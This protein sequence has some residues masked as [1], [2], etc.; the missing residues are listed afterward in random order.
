MLTAGGESERA[1]EKA[2]RQLPNQVIRVNMT[3]TGDRVSIRYPLGQCTQENTITSVSFLP[4][5]KKKKH[6]LNLILG[7]HQ[8]DPNEGHY[9]NGPCASKIPRSGETKTGELFGLKEM[10]RDVPGP[11]LGR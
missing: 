5:K 11:G 10:E 1:V 7:K 9:T 3:S 8:T 6:N 2:G 4:K